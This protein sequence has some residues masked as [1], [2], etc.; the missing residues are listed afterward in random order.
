MDKVFGYVMWSMQHHEPLN[1]FMTCHAFW[2]DPKH[3]S[4]AMMHRWGYFVH[5]LQSL[6]R[7]T[8]FKSSEVL[9]PNYHFKFRDIRIEA[10]K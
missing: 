2:G 7:E 8:G 4:P 9:E 6:M 1:P 5:E 3:K 10:V